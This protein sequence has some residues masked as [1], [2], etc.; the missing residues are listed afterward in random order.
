MASDPLDLVGLWRVRDAD[1]VDP[2][3]WLRLDGWS[4]SVESACGSLMGGWAA[5]G[6]TFLASEPFGAA[7]CPLGE[8]PTWLMGVVSYE[9]DGDGW[10]LL[11]AAG[12]VVAR[13]HVD[14]EPEPHP[15]IWQEHR[16]NP[17]VTEHDRVRFSEPAPLP[18]ELRPA[19]LEQ[20]LGRWRAEAG[21]RGAF[22]EL[23]EDG[24]W[25]G[26]DGCN[27]SAGSWALEDD[28]RILATAGLST[29]IGCPWINLPGLLL[30]AGRVGVDSW[31]GREMLVLVGR[32]GSELV[33]LVSG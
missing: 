22:L 7:G 8:G 1:G 2:E 13:L 9:P 20:L 17:Q 15:Q 11:D 31:S 27:A 26:S 19:S 29:L 30:D 4:W 33:R 32:D 24:T 14:G 10:R 25:D 28:A 18:D 12:D 5:S 6:R 16:V 3:T 23:H 21:G